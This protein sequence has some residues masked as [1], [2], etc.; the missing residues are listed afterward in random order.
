M[1][2][3]EHCGA[4]LLD[5]A[6]LCPKCGCWTNDRPKDVEV[7]AHAQEIAAPQTKLSILSLVGFI[8][9]IVGVVLSLFA[10]VI[11]RFSEGGPML[12]GLPLNIAGFVCSIVGLVRVKR[13][14]LRGKG[15]AIAGIVVGAVV[16]ACYVLLLIFSLCVISFVFLWIFLIIFLLTI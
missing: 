2:Y 8:L 13:R 1:K 10:V 16:G 3:C 12:T 15:F 4:E 14:K 6:V 5:E 11:S 9:S 7:L